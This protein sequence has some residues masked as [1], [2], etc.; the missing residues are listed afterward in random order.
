[1]SL[2]IAAWVTELVFGAA[3]AKSSGI[4]AAMARAMSLNKLSAAAPVSALL[5]RRP[6]RPVIDDV[7][8]LLR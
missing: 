6:H 5:S 4:V 2:A 8:W 7:S 3:T 1:M